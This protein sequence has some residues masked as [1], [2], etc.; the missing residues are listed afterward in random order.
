MLESVAPG[1]WCRAVPLRFLGLE[2]G[3]RMTLLRLSANRLLVHSPIPLTPELKAEV[4]A[5]GTVVGI[6][7]PSLFHHL[8]VAPWTA[9][10]PQA[11]AACCP[12]LERKRRDLRWQR[13]LRDTPE[14]E[15]RDEVDQV[16]FSANTLADEVV[17]FH[18]QSCTLVCS[19]VVFNLSQHASPLTR[20]AAILLGNREPGATLLE[21]L[22]IR[23]R[24]R[25]REQIDR[26]LAWKPERIVL[27]H[28]PILERDASQV[29]R[30]A[31]AWL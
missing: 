9:A 19:D 1:I 31:F 23:D 2:T 12:G 30:R 25:A 24:A 5:L 4:D 17:F 10:Y 22:M 16:H 11:I 7:A 15:W 21:R 6:V 26:M 18:R 13:V 27:A 20:A 28:G 29:L 3:T 8:Y 14:A